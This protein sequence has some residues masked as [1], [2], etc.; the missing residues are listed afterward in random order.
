[1]GLPVQL[2]WATALY[3]AGGW[4]AEQP[5]WR[6]YATD[7]FEMFT[8]AEPG[9]ARQAVGHLEGVW[10]RLLSGQHPGMRAPAGRFKVIVFS[11]ER[12][13]ARFRAGP[14]SPAYFVGGPD[15][16]FVVL[17]RL[18]KH[19]PALLTHETVHAFLR[20]SGASYPWWVEEGLAEQIARPLHGRLDGSNAAFLAQHCSRPP[21]ANDLA[22]CYAA[23]RRQVAFLLAAHA[24]TAKFNRAIGFAVA[25][26]ADAGTQWDGSI[27]EEDAS[28]S[29]H[30][31]LAELLA[32]LGRTGEAVEE[33]SL[34][35]PDGGALR[36]I[37]LQAIARGRPDEG[38]NL[39][40]Q[41]YRLGDR[42]PSMLRALA[43]A[44]QSAPTGGF[45]EYM[46]ALVA[47]DPADDA[48]RLV[49]ASH[50]LFRGDRES[51][52]RHL[53]AIQEVPPPQRDYFRRAVLAAGLNL[54]NQTFHTAD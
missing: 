46:E 40:S 5:Q 2:I 47:A 11:S 34:G 31:E 29:V 32:R 42:D 30:V 17:G 4:Q 33:W 22:A 45:F 6:R 9:L 8:P 26:L 27:Y 14:G 18:T 24:G 20:S 23:A 7:H 41:A 12:D 54:P 38:L 49:L 16:G 37:G 43:A 10:I 28:W 19:S 3:L 52:R 21:G 51:A 39:L 13:Y 44:E 35:P 25:P 1:L 15:G 50:Y 53:A 36:A 48:S